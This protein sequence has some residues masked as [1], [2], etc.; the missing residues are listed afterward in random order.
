ELA[1]RGAGHGA[2]PRGDRDGRRDAREVR[3]HAALGELADI[4]DLARHVLEDELRRRAVQTDHRDPWSFC[5]PVP[6]RRSGGPPW[7][8]G[9]ARR[10]QDPG[11]AS[12][13]PVAGTGT[14]L[15]EWPP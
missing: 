4:R 1:R 10:T 9:A 8:Q 6:P 5:H 3:M 7:K 2:G 15:K 13:Y 14:K 11:S 12:L